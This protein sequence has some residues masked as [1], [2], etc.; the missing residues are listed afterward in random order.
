MTRI[1][2]S[3]G[4]TLLLVGGVALAQSKMFPEKEAI[5]KARAQ[6]PVAGAPTDTLTVTA[7]SDSSTELSPNTVYMFTCG[8]DTHVRWSDTSTCTAVA[9]DF[10]LNGGTIIY[11]A[12]GPGEE[13][14][15][16]C[17]IRNAVD[18][19]CYINEVR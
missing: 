10:R 3:V 4:L 17:G 13:A 14:N 18:G 12:T 11:F 15:W 19:T 9:T 8:E 6:I 16:V 1:L 5:N 7:A 2:V